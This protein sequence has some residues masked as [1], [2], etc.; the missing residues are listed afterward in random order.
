MKIIF[1]GSSDFGLP[2]LEYIKKDSSLSLPLIVTVPDRKSGRK[3]KL[4]PS[5]VKKWAILNNISL[6]TPEDLN[7]SKFISILKEI[8]P[9]MFVVI[10]FRKIPE[11]VFTIPK[12][13]TVNVHASL[14]P[15]YRGAAP[16]QHSLMNGEVVTG[17]STF[18]INNRIDTGS[19]I[20]QLE[21][22][23]SYEDDYG[24]LYLK[25]SSKSPEIL[26]ST[27]LKFADN[28]KMLDL[29]TQDNS[30]VTYAPKIINSDCEIDWNQD[31]VDIYN[32]IRALYPKPGAY[33]FFDGMRI[34]IIK[35]EVISRSIDDSLNS[36]QIWVENNDILV[37]SGS[38]AIKI[39]RLQI[40]GKAPFNGLDFINGYIKSQDGLRFG[41]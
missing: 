11:S 3:Q 23:I 6:E 38:G 24:S 16:I 4:N 35:T 39:I 32:K 28:K 1:F 22:P 9:D 18:I 10:A 13:G 31:S 15:K 2:S 21:V 20:E 40:E 34:K 37:K 7:N 27:I 29:V 26:A 17:L 8:N 14:L 30:C 12:Y 5:P 25:L 33:S 36:G 19:I 41:K